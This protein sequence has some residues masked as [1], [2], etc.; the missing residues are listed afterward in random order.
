MQ[1]SETEAYPK[2]PDREK[3]LKHQPEDGLSFLFFFERKEEEARHVFGLW[4]VGAACEE[5]YEL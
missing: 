4:Y 5:I 2:A 3:A 1:V